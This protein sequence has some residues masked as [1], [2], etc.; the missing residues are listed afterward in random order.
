MLDDQVIKRGQGV[1]RRGHIHGRPAFLARR[2]DVREI[3]LFVRCAQGGEQVKGLVQNAVRISMGPV[4]LVQHQDG[5]QAKLKGL[6]EHELGLGHD[7]L[8]GIDQQQTAIDHAQ[9]AL[10]LAAEIGVAGGVDDIDPGLAR[11]AIPKHAGAL[12]QN[13]NAALALL[14]IRVHG[15]LYRRLIGSENPGLGQ[16]LVNQ[17]GLAVVNVSDDCDV[18]QGLDR[19]GHDMRPILCRCEMNESARL[20]RDCG[21]QSHPSDDETLKTGARTDYSSPFWAD[22]T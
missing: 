14:V 18:T 7:A 10:N 19:G 15:P 9:D 22:E 2:I 12:G 6:A 17:C 16:Q 5:A 11:H 13:R 8:F 4:D 20:V 3:Q 21:Q 1:A